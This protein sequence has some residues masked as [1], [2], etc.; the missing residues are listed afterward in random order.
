[1]VMAVKL[2]EL[3]VRISFLPSSENQGDGDGG[4]INNTSPSHSDL[5]SLSLTP[6]LILVKAPY[7]A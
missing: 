6:V 4:V 2:F 7:V 3:Y 5:S 1:M